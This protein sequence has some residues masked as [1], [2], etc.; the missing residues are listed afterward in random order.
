VVNTNRLANMKMQI[1]EH[2]YQQVE[3]YHEDQILLVLV[4]L[5]LRQLLVNYLQVLLLLLLVIH[6]LKK[7]NW[8]AM[9]EERRRKFTTSFNPFTFYWCY[10]FAIGTDWNCPR[11]EKSSQLFKENED[12]S[13]TNK[14][15]N[16]ENDQ[17]EQN[18]KFPKIFS[19]V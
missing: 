13:F 8:I 18:H 15:L 4:D 14:L 7:I 6:H 10:G 9:K 12:N 2:A 1:V 17:Y 5:N 16:H 3:I 19:N 11:N